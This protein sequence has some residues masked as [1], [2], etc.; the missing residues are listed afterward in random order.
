MG[1]YPDYT[2][3]CKTP[4]NFISLITAHCSRRVCEPPRL[5]RNVVALINI[6]QLGADSIADV[7][8]SHW[9][10]VLHCFQ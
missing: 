1:F 5:K 9:C 8:E 3:G 10:A 4:E 6:N 7:S 2:D